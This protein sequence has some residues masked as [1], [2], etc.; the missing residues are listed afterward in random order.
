MGASIALDAADPD[1]EEGRGLA[2]RG[3]A[4]GERL[5][6]VAGP[7]RRPVGEIDDRLAV[8]GRC[9]LV[10]GEHREVGRVDE[11]LVL[12]DAEDDEVEDGAEGNGVAHVVPAH[13][14]VVGDDAIGD[15]GGVVG[16]RWQGEEVI[17]LAGKAIE[18]ALPG[19]VVQVP[20]A[21]GVHPRAGERIEVGLGGE[22]A[23]VEQVALDILEGSLD[24][25]FRTSRGMHRVRR[26]R[27]EF[28][29]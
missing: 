18:G 21:G 27:C 3:E 5:D 12:G 11:E 13:E 28:S 23:G 1:G 19:G 17:L 16:V 4:L 9:L 6:I 7:L 26:I 22:R 8:S 14:G 29:G 15:L 24:L 10:P 20:I 2:E 25:P